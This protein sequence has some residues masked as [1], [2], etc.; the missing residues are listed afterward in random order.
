[1]KDTLSSGSRERRNCDYRKSALVPGRRSFSVL[2]HVLL[3][4]RIVAIA[5]GKPRRSCLCSLFSL[6]TNFL[7]LLAPQ[8]GLLAERRLI[9]SLKARDDFSKRNATIHSS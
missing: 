7:W 8:C 2:A 5:I 1:M 6:G 4:N 3:A 9:V